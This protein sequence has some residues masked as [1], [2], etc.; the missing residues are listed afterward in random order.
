MS[1]SSD[2]KRFE[3][4]SM[5]RAQAAKRKIVFDL[6]SAIIRDTPVDTGRLAGNWQTTSGAP[7]TGEIPRRG[8][9]LAMAAIEKGIRPM[10]VTTYLSNNLPYAEV[11]EYGLYPDPVQR[12]TWVKGKPHGH[13]EVRSVAGYSKK[14]PAGMVRRNVVRFQEIAEKAGIAVKN[15]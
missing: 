6:F 4:K 13:Y 10:D 2:L 15:I 9:S 5:E 3:A 14:A 11:V 8:R 12:G 1:F 7:A